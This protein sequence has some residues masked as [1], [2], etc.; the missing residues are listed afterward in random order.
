MNGQTPLRTAD[1]NGGGTR[2]AAE[3]RNWHESWIDARITR[4][5]ERLD[6]NGGLEEG[7]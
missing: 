3:L 7:Q 5:A 6:E 1:A 2:V 4:I